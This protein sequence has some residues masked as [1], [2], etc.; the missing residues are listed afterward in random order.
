MIDYYAMF[1]GIVSVVFLVSFAITKLTPEKHQKYT[2]VLKPIGKAA[3]AL[4]AIGI[5]MPGACLTVFVIAAILFLFIALC[6][7]VSILTIVFFGIVGAFVVVY[8]ALMGRPIW[9]DG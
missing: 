2:F 3:F 8:A 7:I 1:M 6:A 5:L 9:D 4:M